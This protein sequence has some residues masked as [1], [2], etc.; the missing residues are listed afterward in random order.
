MTGDHGNIEP[1]MVGQRKIVPFTTRSQRLAEDLMKVFKMKDSIIDAFK[2]G[3]VQRTVY[4]HYNKIFQVESTGQDKE[5]I[6]DLLSQGQLVYHILLALDMQGKQMTL[7]GEFPSYAFDKLVSKICYLC[8]PLDL[9]EE[10]LTE[11]DLEG[12]T[13]QETIQNY[14][15]DL[16]FEAQQG[17]LRAYVTDDSQETF[18]FSRIEVTVVRGNLVLVT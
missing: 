14:I 12:A 5:V 10:A 11:G 17:I 9:Y 16:I 15:D 13:R 1:R 8:V 3:N 7:D 6:F 4:V 18:T 2:R